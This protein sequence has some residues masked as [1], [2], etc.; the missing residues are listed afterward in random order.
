MSRKMIFYDNF[1]PKRQN[2][3]GCRYPIS[4]LKARYPISPRRCLGRFVIGDY[5]IKIVRRAVWRASQ[6]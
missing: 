4:V 5:I 2:G 1:E 6:F 3:V